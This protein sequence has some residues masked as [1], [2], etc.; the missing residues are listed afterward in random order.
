LSGILLLNALFLVAGAGLLWGLRGWGSWSEVVRLGG[1]AYMLGVAAAGVGATLV[2]VA[3]GGLST[4]AIL[5]LTLGIALAGVSAGIVRKR[6]LPRAP[7]LSIR[8]RLP[9]T[10]EGYLTVFLAA[11]V[12]VL[13]VDLFRSA[14]HEPLISWDAWAFWVPK[15]K[16]I[17]FFGG[18]DEQL[19]RSLPGP[20]YPLLVP[21][22]DAMDFRLMGTPDTSMLAVQYWFLFAGFSLAAAGMLQRIARPA[23]T[24]LFIA[25]AAVLPELD[26]RLLQQLGDWP[27]DI[28]FALGALALV[29]WLQTDASW[30]LG[31]YTIMTAAMF[32]TK[33]E[34]Q[35]LGACLVGGALAATVWRRRR[36]SLSILGLTLVAY[37]VN[38]PWR[39]WWTSRGLTPDTPDGGLGQMTA[40]SDRI[41]PGLRLV[42]QLL[43]N[44]HL[45]LV[46]TPVV[47][48]AA[49]IG[50]ASKERGVPIFYL[51]TGIL[52][53]VGFAWIIWS[54]PSLPIST[55][56]SL[57][58][59]PRAVG[60]IALL[61]VALAPVLLSLLLRPAKDAAAGP[62]PV[63]QVVEQTTAASP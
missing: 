60:A 13:L 34:G 20:S 38:I 40:N 10:L 18:L 8:A 58:P 47:I 43:F 50:L 42:A 48:A 59:I 28:F 26:H 62:E 23:L 31:V 39:L 37:A 3:G 35:L 33:R 45:W 52:A 7:R 32:A 22:L 1:V 4:A 15:A 44:P 2:L 16:A 55:K 5:G 53:I 19:F 41:L 54:I 11:V 12:F 29:C 57:T 63:R 21:A 25:T 14:Y 17:Y 30:F 9:L 49:L 24:W 6:P 27:L 56:P 36:A 46:A 51:V 61:S